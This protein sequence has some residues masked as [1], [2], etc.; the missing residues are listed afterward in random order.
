MVE[1]LIEAKDFF[2]QDRY[3]VAAANRDMCLCTF[4]FG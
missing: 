1:K 2:E 4:N 3:A